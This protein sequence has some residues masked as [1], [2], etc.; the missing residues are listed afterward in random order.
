MIS[1]PASDLS[2]A[3]TLWKAADA[4]RGQVDAAG[5]PVHRES[6][7]GPDREHEQA[8]TDLH[9]NSSLVGPSVY[10]IPFLVTRFRPVQALS[11]SG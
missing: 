1:N 10:P 6:E 11:S 2:Y 9:R 5:R 4:L 7:N 8:C 3:D